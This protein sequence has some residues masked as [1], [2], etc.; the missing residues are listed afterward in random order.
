MMLRPRS[1]QFF[2][3]GV[4]ASVLAA[5]A[6]AGQPKTDAAT[7]AWDDLGGR[8][9]LVFDQSPPE[10]NKDLLKPCESELRKL[11]PTDPMAAFHRDAGLSRLHAV[12][13]YLAL[14]NGD[15]K[16][17]RAELETSFSHGK[18][19]GTYSWLA[20]AVRGQIHQNE[21]QFDKAL[22]DLTV[23]VKL[24]AGTLYAHVLRA[25][26]HV[27]LD[28]PFVAMLDYRISK[29]KLTDHEWPKLAVEAV[30]EQ[31]DLKIEFED[32]EEAVD[33]LNQ[34]RAFQPAVAKWDVKL[35]ELY[36][37]KQ[38][39]ENALTAAGN[40]L[41]LEPG[42]IRALQ[43]R[44]RIYSTNQPRNLDGAIA[45]LKALLAELEKPPPKDL[46]DRINRSVVAI[47]ATPQELAKLH[48]DKGDFKSAILIMDGILAKTPDSVTG[49]RDRSVYR[50]KSGNLE[51]ALAD[52]KKASVIE[53]KTKSESRTALRQLAKVELAMGA[54]EKGLT[55]L[56][57]SWMTP[58]DEYAGMI[59]VREHLQRPKSKDELEA[60]LQL[61][62][63]MK[64]AIPAQNAGAVGSRL[65]CFAAQLLKRDDADE[66]MRQTY[67]FEIESDAQC[68]GQG[69]NEVPSPQN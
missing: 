41:A 28:N 11:D 37:K 10:K 47:S 8:C 62:S 61:L 32:Y 31:A 36:V 56:V 53:A 14:A 69:G 24:S 60:Q 45:D 12:R 6:A 35:A 59:D 46:G 54:I 18:N 66:A 1:P 29:I 21:K 2:V 23:A 25:R 3:F 64:K 20:Y 67:K 26:L 57:G 63:K 50:Q 49:L 58:L 19:F 55:S 40:A 4:V 33:H 30:S 68:D 17:A 48:N 42:N 27:A 65:S 16:A 39:W 9:V 34:L 7:N 13:A 44:Y 22:Y 5:S 38:E 43:L 52:A 15:L 51:A